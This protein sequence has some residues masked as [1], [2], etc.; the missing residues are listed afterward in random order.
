LFHEKEPTRK[1]RI[2]IEKEKMNFGTA[3]KMTATRA[4]MTRKRMIPANTFL[5]ILELC[6][7]GTLKR[8][9][10]KREVERVLEKKFSSLMNCN[11]YPESNST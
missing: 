4:P 11:S 6:F 9:S 10:I 3:P 8:W 2:E 1:K 5:S 7:M